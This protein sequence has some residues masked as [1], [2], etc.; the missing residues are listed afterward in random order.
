M[1]KPNL[2]SPCHRP[3]VRVEPKKDLLDQTGK[4]FYFV[5]NKC[6]KACDPVNKDAGF[7]TIGDLKNSD[8]V[9]KDTFFLGCHPGLNEDHIEYMYEAVKAFLTK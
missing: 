7:V 2:V 9:F 5:C 4:T 1:Y 8:K 3:N 6:N